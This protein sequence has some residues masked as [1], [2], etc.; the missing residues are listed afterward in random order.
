[1]T[2]RP[3]NS[4]RWFPEQA[5]KQRETSIQIFKARFP[6]LC[7]TCIILWYRCALRRMIQRRC[8]RPHERHRCPSG[9][10]GGRSPAP[11]HAYGSVYDYVNVCVWT[12]PPPREV[13]PSHLFSAQ[14]C[15]VGPAKFPE[16][17]K[18]PRGITFFHGPGIPSWPTFPSQMYLCM[19][20]IGLCISVDTYTNTFLYILSVYVSSCL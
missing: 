12:H 11:V 5:H 13:G 20:C 8:R 9:P 6:Y 4:P 16:A 3:L 19:I 1:M 18:T 14:T 7:G 10:R 2:F 17:A 15:Q